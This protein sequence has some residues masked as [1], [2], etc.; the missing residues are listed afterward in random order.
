ML[1]LGYGAIGEQTAKIAAAFGMK[2][3]GIRRRPSPP[4]SP[5]RIETMDKLPGLLGEAD[6]VVNILPYTPET[7]GCMGAKE[8]TLMK[9]GAVYVNVGRG[10]TND[11]E[12]L[13]RA[14]R[15]GRLAAAL[16]DVAAAEPLPQDSP[17]W[18]LENLIITPHYAGARS[19]YSALAIDITLENLRRYNRGEELLHLVDKNAGY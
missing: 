4:D 3:I 9:N 11:E 19:D 12:A 13:A 5:F 2:I 1:I 18:D 16:L 17:L 8:F 14:I 10:L 6:Y 15:S 7:K